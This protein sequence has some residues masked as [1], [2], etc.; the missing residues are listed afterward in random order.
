MASWAA[1]AKAEPVKQEAKHDDVIKQPRVAVV[2]ANAIIN[3]EHLLSLMRFND[4][5]VTVP[6][7][8]REVRDKQSRQTLQNLPYTIQTEEPSEE[9]VKSVMRF[10]RATGDSHSLSSVDVRLLAL[11]H[12]LE[13]HYY[14][15]AHLRTQPPPPKVAKKKA[16]DSKHLPGWGAEGGDW[17]ELDKLNEEEL[18]AAEAALM[19]GH[20]SRIATTLQQLPL[21]EGLSMAGMSQN[22][23]QSQVLREGPS[24]LAGAQ[25]QQQ[26]E[27]AVAASGATQPPVAPPHAEDD[28][29]G[30]GA[31]AAAQQ[32][33]QRQEEAGREETG[34][35]GG[36]DGS[37]ESEGSEGEDEWT[38]AARTKNVQRRQRRRVG[39]R[40]ADVC[41]P[42]HPTVPSH[43]WRATNSAR[44]LALP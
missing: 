2:D 35:A 8:L 33:Q 30:L 40:A 21:G 39:A 22:G 10:A 43:A 3:G 28:H 6:E 42:P 15:S 38:Q 5:L 34:T 44:V 16:R 24:A 37:S 20:T 36:D 32:A 19:A 9:S 23:H 11:A 7:V 12:T 27:C 17:A 25:K 13:V 18:A 14:G 26:H 31:A 1:I 41:Q 4:K 29:P